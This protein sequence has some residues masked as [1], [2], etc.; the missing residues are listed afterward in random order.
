MQNFILYTVLLLLSNSILA[1]NDE[2]L[3]ETVLKCN[4]RTNCIDL[5]EDDTKLLVGGEN[6]TVS[7]YD[8]INKKILFETVAH[9][10]PVVE[11]KFSNQ[12]NGFYTVGDKSF[13]F[14]TI[15][16]EKPE[17]IY[18]GSNTSITD[19]DFTPDEQFF[20]AGA[21]E[22]KYRYWH[23]EELTVPVTIDT[24]QTKNVISIAIDKDNQLVACGS[25]DKTIEIWEVKNH[26]RK[27]KI[28]A[29][30]LPVCCLSFTKDAKQL[31]SASHD[32]TA[33]LWEVSTGKNLKTFN[34]HLKAI[35]NM[36]ISPNGHY[37][38][39]ASYDHSIHL[40]SIQTGDLIYRYKHHETP[41]LDVKWNNN[42]TEFLSCDKDGDILSWRVDPK[43]FVDFYFKS[44]LNEEI[45]N[46]PLF[47]PKKKNESRNDFKNRQAD[48]ETHMNKLIKNYYQ[49]YLLQLENQS[50]TDK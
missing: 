6:E 25:Y 1:Q 35:S 7:V 46:N 40:Y 28:D 17:K 24:Y 43:V 42:G 45:R 9:F 20:V 8:L 47:Q 48:A 11:V 39:T 31:I 22:K 36:A 44:E 30:A 34:G 32:G 4:Y 41:V 23:T 26:S 3:N 12:K 27:L 38:L 10:Q 5:N 50:S 19:W 21:F 13:K 33:K 14:W 15:G 49:K 37:L 2:Y 18:T 29:H 16:N